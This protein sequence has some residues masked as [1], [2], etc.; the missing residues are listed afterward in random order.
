MLDGHDLYN[1]ACSFSEMQEV[2]DFTQEVEALTS[3]LTRVRSQLAFAQDC[4]A[5]PSRTAK[6]VSLPVVE[7]VPCP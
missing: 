7:S 3:E 4:R 5:T 6:M 1:V 2:R